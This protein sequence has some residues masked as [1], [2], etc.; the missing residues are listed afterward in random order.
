ME[1]SM[2][3]I[4]ANDLKTR[5]VS[6][7]QEVL[8]NAHEAVISVRGRES[9]VVMDWHAYQKCRETELDAALTEVKRDLAAGRVHKDSVARHLKRI[10]S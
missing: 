9:Y 4:S 1:V 6:V 3:V 7:L 5:G 10:G 8:R 2:T